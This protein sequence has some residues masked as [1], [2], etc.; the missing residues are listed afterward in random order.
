MNLS[1]DVI[2]CIFPIYL[3]PDFSSTDVA[4]FGVIYPTTDV[5]L[6]LKIPWSV[7]NLNATR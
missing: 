1:V 6:D 7:I 4:S 5:N 3:L 2:I